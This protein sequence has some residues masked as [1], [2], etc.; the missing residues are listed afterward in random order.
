M[1]SIILLLASFFPLFSISQTFSKEEITRWQQQAKSVT[2]IRD[3]WGIPHIYGKTDADAVFGLLYAQCEDD[4]PRVEANYIEKLGRKSEVEGRK[5]IYEDLLHRMILDS[6]EAK[7]DYGNAAPWLKKLCEAFAD[8]VNY[9][10]A[11]HP[12]VKPA[13][14]KRFEPWWPL[15]WTDGSIGAISTGGATRQELKAFY[16]GEPLAALPPKYED[17]PQ[18]GSNGFAFAPKLT[19][20][21]KA[22]LYI[23]PHVTFYFRPEVHMVSEEGLNA[24]GAVTWGQFFIY[25]GFNEYCGWMHTSSQADVADLYAVNVKKDKNGFAYAYEGK[26]RPVR[27]K[28]IAISVLEAGNLLLKEHKVFE[29]HHGPVVAERDGKWLALKHH[30]RSMKGLEQ[31]WLRT[32]ATSFAG[33]KQVMYMKENTSNNTVYADKEGNIAY[34]HGN[35]MPKRDPKLDWSKP[36]DGTTSKTEW[37]PLHMVDDM[38]TIYN[39]KSGWIQNCNSTPSTVA[40]ES[41]P[42]LFNF[43]KYMA[44]DAEN[45]RGIN[46]VRH[47][48]KVLPQSLD[49]DKTIAIGYTPKLPAMEY[50]VPALM[51]ALKS[52]GL[53]DDEYIDMHEIL[54][55]WNFESDIYSIAT[56]LTVETAERMLPYI[57]MTESTLMNDAGFV[58]KLIT[59][60]NQTPDSQLLRLLQQT[61]KDLEARFETWRVPW[62]YNNHYQR[63]TGKISEIYDETKPSSPVGFAAATWGALPSY[64]SRQMQGTKRRYGYSG[65][66]F[67]C[68]VEFGEKVQAKSLLAGGNSNNPA[69][70]HFGDQAD[71]Y[72]MGKFKEVLFY[73]ADVEKNKK[74]VYQP[75]Q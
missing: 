17:D 8:G 31:S 29:T 45:F 12:Q 59:Y 34:W 26:P 15:M 66:S 37:G 40:G 48:L 4:F 43:P 5:A 67:I 46:A 13:L 58:G 50:I 54:E 7:K 11:T 69:S 72:A 28:V 24:Y 39:P 19:K 42:Y 53:T 18:M 1:R 63:L 10:L 38:V 33:F 9:Y 55:Q 41:S 27:E 14:L 57:N 23:N 73:R 64:V 44:P 52:T 61:K 60:A 21:G 36:V 32:K 30:N 35:F 22:I 51:R 49:L 56:T 20:S 16:S 25:Q 70:P 6:A 62:G 74:K 47:C 65:N 75:G 2:I 68:A 71:M 3:N